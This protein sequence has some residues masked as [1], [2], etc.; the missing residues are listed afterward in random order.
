MV[1]A[2]GKVSKHE[3]PSTKSRRP[4]VEDVPQRPAAEPD[5]AERD[6]D[7]LNRSAGMGAGVRGDDS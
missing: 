1:A 7:D 5:R 2:D 6:D 3:V 4:P